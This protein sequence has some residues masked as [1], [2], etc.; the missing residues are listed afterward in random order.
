MGKTLFLTFS[1]LPG[2]FN[3]TRSTVFKAVDSKLGS[4]AACCC[5][6]MLAYVMAWDTTTANFGICNIFCESQGTAVE[7]LPMKEV[8]TKVCCY[9]CHAT[10]TRRKTHELLLICRCLFSFLDHWLQKVL[11]PWS[12]T[13]DGPWDLNKRSET[14]QRH[15]RSMWPQACSCHFTQTQWNSVSFKPRGLTATKTTS[16]V[17]GFWSTSTLS[18]QPSS[19]P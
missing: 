14:A 5:L 19:D 15:K 12:L 8:I 9:Q 17:K 16:H 3:H 1:G 13:M 7:S 11:Y 10:N 6:H 2:N 18:N 4:P